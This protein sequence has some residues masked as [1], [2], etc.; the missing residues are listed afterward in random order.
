V[1]AGTGP[2]CVGMVI[3]LQVHGVHMS[4]TEWALLC[5]TVRPF[6]TMLM[7]I[8]RSERVPAVALCVDGDVSGP[9]H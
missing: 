7:V 1:L 9:E 6:V 5:N 4:R 3:F 8:Q 2:G